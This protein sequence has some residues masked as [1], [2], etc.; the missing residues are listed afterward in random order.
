MEMIHIAFCVNDAYV[1]YICVT[2]KSIAVNNT[3]RKIGIHVL[4]DS[5]SASNSDLLNEVV[6][7]APNLSLQ[8][9]I[10]DDSLLRG[11][12]TGNLTLHT[13]YRLLLSD[14]LPESIS[15]VLYLDAD[16]IV[17][18][19]LDELF[20][21]DMGGIAVAGSLDPQSFSDSPFERC[22]YERAKQ[23][24]CAGVLL[25]N[26]DV[27][28]KSDLTIKIIE[29]AREKKETLIFQD[30]DAINYLCKDSK[31]ILPCRYGTILWLYKMDELY[32]DPFFYKQLYDGFYHPAIIHYIGCHPWQKEIINRHF[33][34]DEWV[35][36][37]KMLKNPVK[38]IYGVKFML[39]V[40]TAIHRILY[41]SKH[42]MGMTA[43]DV[44]SKLSTYGNR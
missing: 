41:P 31:I 6:S 37:N 42:R 30:Q 26:L 35:K 36:Y 17:T 9:H 15:R 40:K 22:G 7:K 20:D 33:M 24:I 12:R 25:L 5:I 13:W 10:V 29:Y 8:V 23:Y 27:W 14:V 16:T 34:H 44:K 38:R 1:P 18:D 28:R 2:V 43:N 21:M 3:M 39:A 32:A 19:N 4:T 11:L